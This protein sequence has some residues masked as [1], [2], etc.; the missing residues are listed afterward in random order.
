MV[1]SLSP[2]RRSWNMGRI[3]GK[4]TKPEIIVRRL[5]HKMGYRFRLKNQ[6]LPGTPDIVLRR[7]RAVIFVQGCFWHRHQKCKLSNTP[8][9]RRIYWQNKFRK[10]I[11]RDK[12]DQSLLA[13][14]GWNVILVWECE[15]KEPHRLVRGLNHAIK[16]QLLRY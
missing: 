7:Y 1:D 16:G 10:N 9:S 8:K 6:G 14:A 13:K 3:R 12:R 2:E 4:N 5:L 11:A 15:T